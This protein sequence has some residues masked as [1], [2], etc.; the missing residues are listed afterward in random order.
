MVL[1][2]TTWYVG[3]MKLIL[4]EEE[5]GMRTKKR[6]AS[7][8]FAMMLT[9]V[10]VCSGNVAIISLAADQ[11]EMITVYVAA[12][13][14]GENGNTVNVDKTAVQVEAGTKA[15]AA[16]KTVLDSTEYKQKYTISSSAWGDSLDEINGL[17][18]YNVGNDWYYWSFYINGG[19][20][21]QGIG[22]YELQ[23]ND[24]ISL[25]YSYQNYNTECS[26]YV[27]D[28]T[29]TA[30][31]S[32]ITDAVANAKA[33]QQVLAKEIYHAQ[34]ADGATVP[35]IDDVNGLYSVFSLVRAGANYQAFYDK[36]VQKVGKQLGELAVNGKTKATDG[37]VITESSILKT[38]VAA[39]SYAKMALVMTAL[40][41]DAAN[42]N[43]FNL[44]AHLVDKS[45]YAASSIY[46]RESMILF[47][48]DSANYVLPEGTNYLTREELVNTA[49]ADVQNQ[50]GVSVSWQSPDSAAMAIQPLAPYYKEAKTASGSSVGFDSALLVKNCDKAMRYLEAVQNTNGS[51][52]TEKGNAW[53][54]AQIMITAGVFNVDI[55]EEKDQTD[56]LK[57]GNTLFTA[58][59][60]FVTAGEQ[61]SVDKSL[62]EFQPEQLLRG[63]NA[64]VRSLEKQASIFDM[65]QDSWKTA[66]IP[67]V[68]K[69]NT[70]N[71]KNKVTALKA[72]NKKVSVK[73]GKTKKIVFIL[74]TQNKNKITTDKYK[75]TVTGQL[76]KGKVQLSKGKLVV[77]VKGKKKGTGTVKATVG[78]KSAKVKVSI[79]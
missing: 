53:S 77:T 54:L 51:Y 11:K 48:I 42:I 46:S 76:K 62:M 27:D 26:C 68:K 20:S 75:I 9:V 21:D 56:F 28:T 69:E 18:T 31:G 70:T 30:T 6:I 49:A 23:D 13:G 32:A 29:K 17:S 50:I 44:I 10:S 58:A 57:N 41:K 3:I 72:K 34:F 64:C 14:I 25:I 61:S 35:G 45:V 12:E 19:Y 38:G 33:Q 22:S 4:F 36:V 43:G 66:D 16:I 60:V 79:K 74:S 63:L 39:Q 55:M 2:K 24:K 59:N 37:S 40:G 52:G 78:N 71:Q 5:I 47:A 8:L 65:R 15:T 73:K 1:R 7:I 67:A